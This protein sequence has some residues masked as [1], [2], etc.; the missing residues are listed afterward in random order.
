MNRRN[1]LKFIGAA[2][3]VPTAVV[4]AVESTRTRAPTSTSIRTA[5]DRM[6]E[7]I[8]R[9]RQPQGAAWIVC[10]TAAAEVLRKLSDFHPRMG[11]VPDLP[12]AYFGE[13]PT[14]LG[15]LRCFRDTY[16]PT[17]EFL[18]GCKPAEVE[19]S[20]FFKDDRPHWHE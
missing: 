6:T 4:K 18:C 10:G 7:E 8:Y 11:L 3:L 5:V 16:L 15:E 20:G 1:F 19:A 9:L 17:D 12:L 14:A 13:L 2:L